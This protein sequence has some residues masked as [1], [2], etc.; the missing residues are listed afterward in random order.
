MKFA[1]VDYLKKCVAALI[2]CALALL[3]AGCAT[4]YKHYATAVEAQ[5]KYQALAESDRAAA[6][7]AALESDDPVARAV[8]ANGLGIVEAL[9][10]VGVGQGGKSTALAAP[11]SFVE[12]VATLVGSFSPLFNAGVQVYGIRRNADVAIAA[13]ANET[14]RQRIVSGERVS[15]FDRFGTTATAGFT[16]LADVGKVPTNV[17]NV[18]GNNNATGVAGSTATNTQTTTTTSTNNCPGGTG[19][20]GSAS[21]TPGTGGT[22]TASSTGTTGTVPNCQ[23]QK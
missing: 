7:K 11:K 20:P 1:K 9:R 21:S 15:L 22:T 14:E 2:G 18:T 12:E 3:A 17:T 5:A 19:V 4:D 23:I 13:Q 6:F 8:A 16:A 10:V